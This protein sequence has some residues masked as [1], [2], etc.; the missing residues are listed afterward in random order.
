MLTANKYEFRIDQVLLKLLIGSH[1]RDD[2]VES[3]DP[4]VDIIGP[5]ERELTY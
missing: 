4:Q 1:G 5:P 3:M 2:P